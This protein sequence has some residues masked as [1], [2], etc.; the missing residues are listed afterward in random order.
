MKLKFYAMAL[1]LSAATASNA[2]NTPV[3]QMEKLD[4]GLVAVNTG[5]G[6]FVSWRFFGTDNDNTTFKVLRN[7]SAIYTASDKT[8]FQD[9]A[10]NTSSEYQVVTLVDGE[11]VDTSAAIKPWSTLYKQVKLNRP[12]DGS[13]E[14]GTYTY[15]PN[16]CSVGDVDGDG[17]YEII[18]KWDPSN[19]KDNS[20]SGRTGN[21]YLDCYELDGT[22]LWRID[23]G[24]NIRA[25]AHYTQYLV[26]DFDKDGKA[27]LICKTAPGSIDGA[28]NYV[29]QAATDEKIKAHNNA[30]KFRNSSGHVLSGAEYLTVFNGETGKAMHTIWYNPNRAGNFNS[31]G[32]HPSDKDFWGDNYGNRAERYLACVAYLDGPDAKPSAIMQKGYYTR[33]YV[34]AVDWD[35]TALKTKWLHA[36]VSTTKME[37]YDSEFKKTTKY[38]TKT[39]RP[40]NAGSKTAHSNGNHNISV[41]DVDGDG[42]DEI[43]HGSCAIDNDGN[44]LYATGFGHGDAIHLGD[45]VPD[46]PG[47]ELFQIHESSPYGWDLHDAATGE[48]LHSATGSGDNGRGICGNFDAKVRG[49]IFWSSNDG[50]ARSAVTGS[51]ISSKHGSSN[52]RIYWD[53]DLLEDLLDGNTIDKWNGNGTTRLK[54]ANGKNPYDMASSSTCNGTKKTPNLSA[55]ILGDWREELILWDGSNSAA[56]NIFTS[57]AETKFR[58]PTLM[59]DHTYR[60]G[61]AWQNCAYNQPPH[62][63]YYLPDMFKTEFIAVE[64]DFIQKVSLGDSIVPLVAIWKNCAAPSIV[65]SIAPDGT[66]TT[67]GAMSGFTFKIDKYLKKEITLTGKPEQLGEYQFIFKSGANVAD[68]SIKQDTIRVICMDPSGIEGIESDNAANGSINAVYN[69]G[70][71]KTTGNAKGINIIKYSDGRKRKIIK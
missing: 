44:L 55:D 65:K 47:L 32:A 70:G 45:H 23:L 26:Y 2:Q 11:P 6:N 3:S 46:R 25:G 37:I 52:G 33:A 34:W 30:T 5:S 64:G 8:S 69:V 17:Q 13:N 38:N 58:V 56:L 7:G 1:M 12:A 16:D 57:T 43:I 48:L 49:S 14:D 59:H 20:Q 50:S 19:S 36:S 40:S 66:E 60:M 63:G 41:A 42:C 22:Q 54:L 68:N 4:R 61:V 31:V 53:G 10:G 21:V 24:L 9:S 29:N 27:E 15:S 35:G 51:A 71:M 62:L 67:G 39:S 18:V 28:G